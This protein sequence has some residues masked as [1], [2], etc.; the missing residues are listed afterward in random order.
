MGM[1]G[2]AARRADLMLA[3]AKEGREQE[4]AEQAHFTPHKSAN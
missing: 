2:S 4:W 1:G 3:G